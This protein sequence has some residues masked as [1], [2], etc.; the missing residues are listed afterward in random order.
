MFA[1]VLSR[2]WWMLLIRGAVSILFGI[3]VFAWPG[4][5]LFSL[6]LLFGAFILADGFGN[7]VTAIGGR[8]EN[9]NWWLLLLAGFAGVALGVLTFFNPGITALALLFYIAIWAIATGLLTIVA[10]IRLRKEIEGELWLGLGGL[11]SVIFGLLLAARPGVG[12]LAVLWLIAAYAV[13]FGLVLVILAFKARG[14]AKR[15]EAAATA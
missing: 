15:I 8:N 3:M 14:F 11:A 12:A 10:A 1:K 13:A 9:E 5:S 2:Y 7:V 6:V 4:I